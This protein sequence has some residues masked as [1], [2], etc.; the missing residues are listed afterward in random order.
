MRHKPISHK[1]LFGAIFAGLNLLCF[2]GAMHGHK[3]VHHTRINYSH[4]PAQGSR[5]S[6]ARSS[7]VASVD[8]AVE[9]AVVLHPSNSQ[10]IRVG[11][12]GPSAFSQPAL[13]PIRFALP[14]PEENIQLLARENVLALGSAPR[15]PG[16][17]R[18]PPTA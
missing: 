15:A 13:A 5:R 9:H 17:G 18:A 10:A 1:L 3:V 14:V 11:H 12:A 4:V 7:V 6:G 2:L 16:L 8:A